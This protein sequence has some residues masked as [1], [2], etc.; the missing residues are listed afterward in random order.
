MIFYK[1]ICLWHHQYFTKE[2]LVVSS[3][4]ALTLYLYLYISYIS[5]YL[6]SISYLCLDT[7]T[8][9]LLQLIAYFIHLGKVFSAHAFTE[10]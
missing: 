3:R 10:F 1:N 8:Y 2:E 9:A 6:I 5:I 7:Q 4:T